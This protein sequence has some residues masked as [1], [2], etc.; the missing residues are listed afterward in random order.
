MEPKKYQVGSIIS[1]DLTIPNADAIKDFYK[2]VIGWDSEA[3]TMS[4][5]QGEYADYVM[6]DAA[7][8]WVG[9]VCHKRGVNVDQPPY[10][11]VYVNVADIAKSAEKC[12]ELGGKVLKESRMADGTLQF[13]LIEDPAGAV[14][15]LTKEA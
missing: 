4:D 15:A 11:I 8:N 9:G 12:R 3:L 6:K 10:W 14:L 13:V 1:A 2:A 7:G 5:E